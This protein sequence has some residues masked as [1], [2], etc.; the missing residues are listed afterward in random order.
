M[1]AGWYYG[2]KCFGFLVGAEYQHWFRYFFIGTIMFGSV[3]SIDVVFNLIAGAYGLMAIPTMVATLLLSGKVM[4]AAR[5]YF[6]H[7]LQPTRN[8]R[9]G[10]P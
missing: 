10:S 8:S 7:P 9:E 4:T 3:V 6:S 1:F 5:E 2:A